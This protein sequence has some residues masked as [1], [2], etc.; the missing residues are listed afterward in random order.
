MRLRSCLVGRGLRSLP[1]GTGCPIFRTRIRFL[2]LSADLSTG[3]PLTGQTALTQG[4]DFTVDWFRVSL[5]NAIRACTAQQIVSACCQQDNTDPCVNITRNPDGSIFIVNQTFQNIA[6]AGVEGVGI[7]GGY[8][9]GLPLLGGGTESL[10]VRAFASHLRTNST[11]SSTG[12]TMDF[13]GELGVMGLPR[14]K[15]TSH[16]QYANGPFTAFAEA[17]HHDGGR[18]GATYNLNGVW[19]IAHNHVGSVTCFDMRMSYDIKK[20]APCSSTA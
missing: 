19:D 1:V 12:V 9:Q 15:L 16:V 3:C 10:L 14:W 6:R 4:A 17:R 18:L 2:I 5:R 20:G 8:T 7:E 13:A 11:T